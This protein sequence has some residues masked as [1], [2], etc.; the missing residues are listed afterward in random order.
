MVFA[1]TLAGEGRVRHKKQSTWRA[2]A[3][4]DRQQKEPETSRAYE[5]VH[6]CP[7]TVPT[8]AGT[9]RARASRGSQPRRWRSRAPRG[10]APSSRAARARTPPGA[11]APAR[12]TGP[13]LRRARR[14]ARPACASRRQSHSAECAEG[15]MAS[16]ASLG[17][18]A[19]VSC[20]AQS[21]GPRCS[22]GTDRAG[23]TRPCGTPSSPSRWYW[24]WCVT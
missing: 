2:A 5:G 10:A 12:G 22:T 20:T 15:W 6:C 17:T 18:P 3:A 1:V 7:L 23:S 11:A 24:G 21:T 16:S 14:P 4:Q 19:S 13:A 8:A 9:A